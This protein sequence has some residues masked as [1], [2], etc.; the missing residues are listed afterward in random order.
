M[1]LNRQI[2]RKKNKN[3]YLSHNFSDKK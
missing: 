3:H 2:I 1:K